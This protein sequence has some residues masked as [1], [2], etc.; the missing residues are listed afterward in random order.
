ME[1]LIALAT[2]LLA[3]ALYLCRR[4]AAR[5]RETMERETA[6]R[7]AVSDS[8]WELTPEEREAGIHPKTGWGAEDP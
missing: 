5:R 8:E 3:V 6:R 4:R 2:P 7:R 1:L